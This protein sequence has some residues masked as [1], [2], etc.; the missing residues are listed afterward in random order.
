MK[1]VLKFIGFLDD[2][3]EQ[4]SL[5]NIALIAIVVKMVC[6]PT[7]DWPSAVTMVTVF[8]NYAH[9]RQVREPSQEI[10]DVKSQVEGIT[11]KIAPIVDAITGDKK[12]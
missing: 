12:V 2:A 7:L 10:A 8:A 6:A 4:L 1:E 5:T 11:S 3:G 9:K